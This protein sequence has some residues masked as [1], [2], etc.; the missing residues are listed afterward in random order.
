MNTENGRVIWI[1]GLSGAGKTSVAKVLY[2]RFKA[3]G[4]QPILLDG[5]ILRRIFNLHKK[6][7]GYYNRKSRLILSQ[8]YSLLCDELSSQGFIVI[9]ATISMYKEIYEWNR[10]KLPNYFEVFL[11]VPYSELRRRDPKNI[12]KDFSSGKIR[13]VAGLDLKVDKPTTADLRVDYKEG[14]SCKN[15]ADLIMKKIMKE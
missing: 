1:T 9:I 2:Q 4:M 8:K 3:R 6:V 15:I 5:D 7:D 10:K 12:Y 14:N 11:N 13:N